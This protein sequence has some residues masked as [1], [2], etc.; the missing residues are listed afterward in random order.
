MNAGG[1]VNAIRMVGASTTVEATNIECINN[2]GTVLGPCA[3]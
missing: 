1:G 3:F 2:L